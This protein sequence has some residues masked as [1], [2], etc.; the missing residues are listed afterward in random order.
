MKRRSLILIITVLVVIFLILPFYY[1]IIGSIEVKDLLGFLW[2]IPLTIIALFQEQLKKELF[3]P[4][5]Q[6]D[7]NLRPPYCLKTQIKRTAVARTKY[8]V[9]MGIT[10]TLISNAYYFRFCTKNKGQSQARLCE[11]IAE[12]LWEYK[13]SKWEKDETFQPINL[14]WSNEKSQDEF[15][16]INPNYPGGF[17]DLVHIEEGHTNL[18]I[19]Y[20]QPIPN[21]Q[22]AKLQPGTKY[23]IK[24]S[25]YSENASAVSKTFEIFWSGK[26]E[27][28]PEEMFKK[29]TIKSF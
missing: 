29:I 18:Y 24:V 28:K 2:V 7:F 15:M 3:A 16:N 17:C 12:N 14:K 27:N 9:E 8:G 22:V 6:I 1:L 11:C 25:L 26:Y 19:D 13:V 23:R 5:L 4:D 10:P 20:K 21:S